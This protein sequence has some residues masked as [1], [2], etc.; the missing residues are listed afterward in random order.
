M[1]HWE[2]NT[3]P[4]HLRIAKMINLPFYINIFH[5]LGQEMDFNLKL[6]G[7][8]AIAEPSQYN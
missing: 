1:H 7:Q 2:A 4:K 8:H 6:A 3:L 5:T